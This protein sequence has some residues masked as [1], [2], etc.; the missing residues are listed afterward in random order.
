MQDHNM[1]LLQ[2]IQ[3]EKQINER[4]RDETVF[5]LCLYDADVGDAG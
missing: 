4:Q 3:Q 2:Y 5:I 1:G